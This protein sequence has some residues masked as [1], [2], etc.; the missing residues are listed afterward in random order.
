MRNARLNAEVM[1]NVRHKNL[2]MLAALI[3]ISCTVVMADTAADVSGTWKVQVSSDPGSASQTIILKQGGNKIT[4]TFQDER[5]DDRTR[6]N[7]RL[8][9]YQK[10]VTKG[11][12][13]GG[14]SDF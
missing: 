3:W 6:K 13:V 2:G 10:R 11:E 1:T 14:R 4:P 9:G 8:G 7:R 12:G 5:N